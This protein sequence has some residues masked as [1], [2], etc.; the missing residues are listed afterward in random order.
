[1]VLESEHAKVTVEGLHYVVVH[2]F[3]NLDTCYRRLSKE[4]LLVRLQHHISVSLQV[5]YREHV[6]LSI[7]NTLVSH[8][9]LFLLLVR[10]PQ[11]IKDLL[12]RG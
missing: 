10:L 12:Q 5:L 2:L 1:M 8:M 9:S 6:A 4:H 3:L 7:E 11:P